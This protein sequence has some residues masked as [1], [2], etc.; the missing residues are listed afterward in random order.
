MLAVAHVLGLLLASFALS[1][2]LPVGC[3]LLYGDGLATRFLLAAAITAAVTA[4]ASRKRVHRPSLS[5]SAQPIG[6]R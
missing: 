2:A 6:S 1:Y 4:A 3:A 5:S